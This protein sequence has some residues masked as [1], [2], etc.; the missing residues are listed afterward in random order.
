M[1]NWKILLTIC[2][3]AALLAGCGGHKD[4]SVSVQ[5]TESSPVPQTT[6]PVEETT[7]PTEPETAPTTE[8]AVTGIDPMDL[9]GQWERTLIEVEGYLEDNTDAVITI[10][11]DS[12]DALTI[13]FQD[14]M[15]PDESF[16]DK[17]LVMD[18]REMFVDCGN[19][20]WVMDV[21]YIG[22]YDTEYT[23]TLLEDGR[24]LKQNYFLI[25]GA[26]MVSYEVFAK[27]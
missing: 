8:P 15:F 4:G 21:D 14:L 17:A 2:M 3:A 22:P 27:K 1:K 20:Q 13:S 24:L 26:P 9:V 5:G 23:V 18:L 7:Q 11:G 12:P 6:Q 19:D 10:A 16:S 25:D